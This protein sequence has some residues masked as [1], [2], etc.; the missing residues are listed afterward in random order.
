MVRKYG[1]LLLLSFFICTS[2]QSQRLDNKCLSIQGQTSF[3]KMAKTDSEVKNL[4]LQNSLRSFD[5][6]VGYQTLQTDSSFFASDYNYPI[7]GIGFSVT[8]FSNIRLTNQSFINNIY[9]MYGFIDRSL[10]RWNGW[11]LGYRLNAGLSYAG[12]GY[13]PINNPDNHFVSSPLMVYVGINMN[14]KYQIARHWSLGLSVEAKHFSNGRLGMPNKGINIYAAGVS[15]TYH[16]VTLQSGCSKIEDKNHFTK[17]F[18]YHLSLGGGVQSSLEEWNLY[19]AAESSPHKKRK[20]FRKYPKFSL[21]TDMIY[22]YS[23]KYGTGMG[24]DLFYTPHIHKL[25]EW[26]GI[27][28]NNEASSKQKYSP[29]AIG[30]SIN[31]EVFY[32]NISLFAAMGYYVYRELGI[33]HNES[34]FYQRAG[35]RYYLPFSEKTFIGTSIKAHKFKMAEYLELSA[36]FKFSINTN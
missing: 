7:L 19:S 4:L 17:Y 28:S 31:Q 3:G 34:R 10:I 9:T 36:G 6:A 30:I 1:Y 13:N 21:S 35:F 12:H 33:Q 22:R 20:D 25:K 8:D 26:D 29:L 27:L 2:M 11:S 15:A 24:F 32:K 23:R 14:M 18:F 5:I 16:F